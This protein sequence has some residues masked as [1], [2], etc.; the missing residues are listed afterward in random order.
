MIIKV[1][2][3]VDQDILITEGACASQRD[4][5]RR[6]FPKGAALTTRNLNRAR[7][8]GLYTT[9]L[10]REI[11][12]HVW[13]QTMRALNKSVSRVRFRDDEARAVHST[14]IRLLKEATR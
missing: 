2:E 11:N 14:Y 7:K 8:L 12:I 6:R 9:W 4:L 10:L 5:F 1:G 13:F 3:L